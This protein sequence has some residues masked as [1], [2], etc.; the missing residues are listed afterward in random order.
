MNSSLRGNQQ[1]KFI[2][3]IRLRASIRGY[4]RLRKTG[5][6]FSL[7]MCCMTDLLGDTSYIEEMDAK[8]IKLGNDVFTI[9]HILWRE[10]VQVC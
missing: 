6:C 2:L 3:I 5:R 1:D 7:G 4:V 8:C 10:A 9:M